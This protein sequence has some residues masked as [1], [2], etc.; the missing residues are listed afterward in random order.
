MHREG[1]ALALQL[2]LAQWRCDGVGQQGL[3]VWADRY[4]ARR[5]LALD[6]GGDVDGVTHDRVGTP[7]LGTQQTDRDWSRVD[8]DPEPRPVRMIFGNAQVASCSAS[9]AP[10][11]RSA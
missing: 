9:P 11:A 6:A 8:P 2:K 1:I 5:R 10:A 3:G 7:A 4:A